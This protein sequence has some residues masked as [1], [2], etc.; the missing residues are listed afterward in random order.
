MMLKEKFLEFG[1]TE[2][3]YNLIR[4]SYGVINYTEETFMQ[5]AIQ[6]MIVNGWDDGKVSVK[7][8]KFFISSKNIHFF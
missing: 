8:I 2:E 3:E 7:C 1:Y 5:N 4:N 6:P